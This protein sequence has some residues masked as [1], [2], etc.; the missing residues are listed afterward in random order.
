MTPV[1]AGTVKDGKLFIDKIEQFKQHLLHFPTVK[2]VGISGDK[3]RHPHANNKQKTPPIE[4]S[5][6]VGY[7]TGKRK[8]V[9]GTAGV[10][11]DAGR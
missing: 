6:F 11:P 5:Y 9:R 4:F 8:Q 1:F 10:V 2:R 7:L 3:I